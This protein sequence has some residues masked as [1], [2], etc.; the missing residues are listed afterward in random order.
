MAT[1]DTKN[2]QGVN[3]STDN[4]RTYE[5]LPR[6]FSVKFKELSFSMARQTGTE[7]QL[8]D[9]SEGGICIE[10]PTQVEVGSKMQVSIHIPLLNKY[11]P[12]F[13]KIYENDADQHFLAITETMWCKPV[14]GIFLVGMKFINVDESQ[15]RAL[16]AMI[17]RAMD[18]VER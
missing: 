9:I 11:S 7:G 8:S 18:D 12:G 2:S 16:A 10:S 6:A 4:A 13:L 5:R 3:E 1:P 14:G 15:A 17:N